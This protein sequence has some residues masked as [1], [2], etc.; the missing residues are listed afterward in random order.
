MQPGGQ[1]LEPGAQ[2][3]T[4]V[5]LKGLS[6][7]TAVTVGAPVRGRAGVGKSCRRESK[8]PEQGSNA[9]RTES[10]EDDGGAGGPE[11][12]R[13]GAR[14][15]PM[16]ADSFR[17]VQLAANKYPEAIATSV[18]RARRIAQAAGDT[19]RAHGNFTV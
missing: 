5:R 2:L 14:N 15:F 13:T 7:G 18:G 16:I 9:R 6:R 10:E 12:T 17:I 4:A 11:K 19:R 8:S 3:E 1:D